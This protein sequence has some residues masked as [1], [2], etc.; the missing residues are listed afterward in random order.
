MALKTNSF[1][2]HFY[3]LEWEW[4]WKKKQLYVKIAKTEYHPWYIQLS[5]SYSIWKVPNN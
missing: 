2:G 5:E 4:K 1:A 3:L